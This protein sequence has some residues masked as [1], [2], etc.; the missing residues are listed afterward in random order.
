MGSGRTF[1]AGVLFVIALV[2]LAVGIMYLTVGSHALPSFIPGHSS[3]VHDTGKHSKK[4]YAGVAAGVVLL[5][6][7]IAMV[8]VGRRRRYRY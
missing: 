1:L 4:G 8:A 3:N 2:A 6:I 5:V 7:S